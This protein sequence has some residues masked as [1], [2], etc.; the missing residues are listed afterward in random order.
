MNR[1]QF[2]S[3]S[4]VLAATGILPTNSVL[5]QHYDENSLDKLTD[6]NGNFQHLPLPPGC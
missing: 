3:A 5:A 1:K 6:A 2:I 4:G